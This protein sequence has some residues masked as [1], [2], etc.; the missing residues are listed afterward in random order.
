MDDITEIIEILTERTCQERIAVILYLNSHY[1]GDPVTFY[2][3][4]Q[5]TSRLGQLGIRTTKARGPMIQMINDFVRLPDGLARLP[6]NTYSDNSLVSA[7][8]ADNC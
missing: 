7:L 1:R 2:S 4:Y 8:I 3:M 6:N 5:G